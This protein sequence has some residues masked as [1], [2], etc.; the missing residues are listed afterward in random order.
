MA[1]WLPWVLCGCGQSGA[2]RISP[3]PTDISP[4]IAPWFE[5]VTE[6][7]GVR[8]VHD[9]GPVDGNY[10]LP[11][12]NGSGA[13]LFDCDHDGR[14]DLY[15]L[16]FGGPESQ[17]KNVF[18]R[19]T[20]SGSFQDASQGSGL[21]IAGYNTG[22]IVGDAD[23]D[24]LPDVVVV[25]YLGLKCF[26]NQGDGKFQDATETAHLANESWGTSASFLDFDRDGWLD[27][28]VANY[29]AY[30]PGR[31]CS[32]RGGRQD[33]CPPT[34]FPG[35]VSLLFRNLGRDASGVWQGYENCTQSSGLGSLPGPGLGALCADFDGDDWP[36]IFIA[37]DARPNHLWINKQDGTFAEEAVVRGLA[38]NAKGDAQANMGIAYGDV[39]DDGLPDLFVTHFFNEHHGLWKQQPRGLFHEQAGSA[40]IT[41]CR[42]HGTGFGTVLGDF[43]QDG[44]L[45]LALTNGHVGAN[46]GPK[47]PFWN[48]YFDRN[49]V[50]MNEGQGRFRDISES[51]PAL[52]ARPNVGRGLCQG[53][54]DGDGALDLV[55]TEIAGPV[56]ILRN[57][58]PQRGHWLIVRAIE[59]QHQRD[60]LGAEVTIT[61]AGHR[62]QRLVQS[63]Y[64]FQS[65]NDPRV[66]F[67]LGDVD[68]IDGIEVR[69]CDGVRERFKQTT[70][71]CVVEIRR[72][73]G[74]PIASEDGTP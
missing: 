63:G 10:F 66:H 6:S 34:N 43:D 36:D 21:D 13:A 50:L 32:L 30:D 40:G 19:Q 18:Y 26:L 70:V 59:P 12:I 25:Q 28:V 24:G 22:V 64:S 72:G 49:Q 1:I 11:Q 23:N 5:D 52:C 20:A 8:F 54:I 69:W 65:S 3:S 15:L 61:A 44:D 60:A 45:D 51:N 55:V 57:V 71:D 2:E 53:D 67:G 16:Q 56:R 35:T 31:N 58:A 37:N 62:W 9:P 17:A 41:R 47:D 38:Y 33:F 7:W 4:P 14:L 42:W 27:L 74:E 29:L 39:D 48:A 68:R 73:M 46:D